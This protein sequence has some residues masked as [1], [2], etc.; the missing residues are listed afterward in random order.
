MEKN[1]RVLKEEERQQGFEARRREEALRRLEQ[2]TKAFDLKEDILKQFKEGAIS[3]CFP[4]SVDGR[5]P[6]GMIGVKCFDPRWREEIEKF[7]RRYNAL[8]YLALA[9]K[10]PYGEMLSMLYV[11]SH[12][13][14]WE[15]E[16]VTRDYIAAYVY[17]FDME[18][19]EF[20]DIFLTSNNGALIR[21]A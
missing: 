8:V 18:E 4:V 17:N 19:G 6:V 21:K 3:Y 15:Y 11:S 1:S 10:S 9:N 13:K 16:G 7:E 14:E 20:G 5:K 12:E 2:L